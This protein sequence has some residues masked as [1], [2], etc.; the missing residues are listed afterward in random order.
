MGGL[1]SDVD[2]H[3]PQLSSP[4][5]ISSL[6]GKDYWQALQ[7]GGLRPEAGGRIVRCRRA[8]QRVIHGAA[9]FDLQQALRH[10]AC[11][12][13]GLQLA[14]D[15]LLVSAGKAPMIP[16]PMGIPSPDTGRIEWPSEKNS[17]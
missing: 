9:G 14:D 3:F 2:K 10:K 6:M 8:C 11:G 7:A 12:N 1:E 15:S 17:I 5:T 16:A 4:F 13:K